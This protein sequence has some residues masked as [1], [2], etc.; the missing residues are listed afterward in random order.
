M[1]IQNITERR[2]PVGQWLAL[3]VAALIMGAYIAFS[4]FEDY[5]SVDTLARERLANQ[6]EII[7]N[8]LERR[9]LGVNRALEGVLGD[10]P[11]WDA[12]KNGSEMAYRRLKA[13][14]DSLD[15]V[16]TMSILDPAGTMIASNRPELLGQNFRQRDYFQDLLRNPDPD[17]LYIGA[18]FTTVL[19]EYTIMVARMIPGPDGQFAGMVSATLDV[20][21]FKALL[22]SLRYAPDLSLGIVHGGGKPLLYVPEPA[23]MTDMNLA[24]PGTFF[25]RHFESGRKS[26]V[27]VG[28]SRIFDGERL[29][30]L[31]TVRPAGLNISQ[32]LLVSASRELRSVFAF[33]RND[34]YMQC[35]L[36]GALI[37]V[38]ALGLYLLQ[39]R[40]FA[41][42]RLRSS[43]DAIK[44]QSAER[45]KLATEAVGIGVWEYDLQNASLIW[46]D[47][48]FA[49]YGRDRAGFAQVYDA[50]KESVLPEDLAQ[51]EA[52][53]RHAIEHRSDFDTVFRIRRGEGGIRSIRAR[54]K[55][56]RDAQGKALRLLGINQDITERVQAEIALQR[57]SDDLRQ[58]NDELDRF[59]RAAVGRE[60]DMIDLKQQV[61]ALSRELGRVAPFDQDFAEAQPNQITQA[62]DSS[63][64]AAGAH[65]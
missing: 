50:W 23:G 14:G 34:A 20:G 51:A 24:K 19:G 27:M 12:Q 61:N 7:A 33:W 62:N 6:A 9:L 17:T 35:G 11:Y 22:D 1:S 63:L 42:D 46:D 49:L 4:L 10:L 55:V 18:P 57:Q 30:A 8:T 58:R 38:A 16:H 41:Y 26:S 37:L 31:H 39:R 47:T 28:Q 43:H 64:H 53:L 32:P 36:Y 59:N 65:R 15:G 5:R 21:D 60:L 44:R 54:S 56:Y 13:M 3:A 2:S 48:M 29:V 40:R 52:A 45:L 25:S